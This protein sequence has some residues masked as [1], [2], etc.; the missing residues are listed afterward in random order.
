MRAEDERRRGTWPSIRNNNDDEDPLC[1][2][3]QG[4]TQQQQKVI[5]AQ[6]MFVLAASSLTLEPNYHEIF[7]GSIFCGALDS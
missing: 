2:C 4:N 1:L 6:L 3:R 7:A 5:S